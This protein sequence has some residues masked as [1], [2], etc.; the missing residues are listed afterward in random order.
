MFNVVLMDMFRS[1]LAGINELCDDA[2]CMYRI[3]Y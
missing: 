1:G 3:G 2:V